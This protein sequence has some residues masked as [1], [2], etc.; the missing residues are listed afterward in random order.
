[1]TGWRT[2]ASESRAVGGLC[3]ILLGL[4]IDALL[5]LEN[6]L[7]GW[8][9]IH[10]TVQ[11]NRYSATYGFRHGGCPASEFVSRPLQMI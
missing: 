11:S 4:A 2:A 10:F 8:F 7:P 5:F 3:T 6:G 1:M 9:L